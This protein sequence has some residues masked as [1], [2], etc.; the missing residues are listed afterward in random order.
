MI[1]LKNRELYP[2]FNTIIKDFNLK[3]TLVSIS[4]LSSGNINATYLAATLMDD[5]IKG[6]SKKI[7]MINQS[8]V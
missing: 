6:Y 3:G 1:R 7:W 8:N 2:I 5:A 4:S